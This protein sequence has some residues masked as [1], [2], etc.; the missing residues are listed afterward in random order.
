VDKKI[1]RKLILNELSLL[2]KKKFC[3]I[4]LLLT[5]QIIKFLNTNPD[6][7]GQTGAGYLPLSREIAPDFRL[8]AQ[9]FSL[10]LSY[11]V[12]ENQSMNFGLPEEDRSEKVW[13]SS[14][15]KLVKPSWIFVPGVAFTFK[16]ER[17]GR[18]KGY[19][20]RY[21]SKNKTI[22]IGISWSSQIK[23]KL[24]VEPH[25]CSMDFIITE[26]FCW[27]VLQQKYL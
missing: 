16:G 18:G 2:S 13:L 6:L 24:P 26:K 4:N 25:D 15:Y 14:P 17:L 19:F 3:S 12:R 20:D 23:K 8:I 11:P 9:R 21:L 5:K 22:K 10:E 27:S 7:L 1:T